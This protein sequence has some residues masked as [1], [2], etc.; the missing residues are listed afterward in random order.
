[1]EPLKP[2]RAVR[3]LSVLLW[4]GLFF[5]VLLHRTAFTTATILQYS[6]HTLPLAAVF[7]LLLYL[8]KGLT[9]FIPLV[10]LET[11]A[12]LLF[13]PIWAVIINL[14]GI[15][16]A[17]V[18][19][20]L[21]GRNHCSDKISAT[22]LPRLRP[23]L[24]FRENGDFCFSFLVRL[25]GILPFDLVSL[26]FGTLGIHPAVCILAGTLGYLPRMLAATFLGATLSTPGPALVISVCVSAVSVLLSLGVWTFFSQKR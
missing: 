24:Q 19:P 20:F 14:L 13:S 3:V 11:T 4:G 5:F 25:C 16:L 26:G 22:A 18:P 9:V 7:L 2:Y 10:V 12:G 17:T 21:V 6:P 8:A 1:M 23:F 15:S